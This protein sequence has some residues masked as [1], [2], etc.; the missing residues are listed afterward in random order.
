MDNLIFIWEKVKYTNSTL[1]QHQNTWPSTQIHDGF[2]L[3]TMINCLI[4]THEI[5]NP[6]ITQ[7][8][9]S[10]RLQAK[11]E[12]GIFHLGPREQRIH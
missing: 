1:T 11:L 9:L 4:I 7:I 6:D 3:K 8:T 12:R 2:Y 5:H 10:P